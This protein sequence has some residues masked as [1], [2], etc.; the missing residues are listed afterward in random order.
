MYPNFDG[1]KVQTILDEERRFH[2]CIIKDRGTA[3]KR[4]HTSYFEPRH[5]A[6]P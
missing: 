4:G 3:N 6:M 5:S 2:P 1:L